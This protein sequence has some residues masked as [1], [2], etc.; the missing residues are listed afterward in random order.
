M[1]CRE[2]ED[3]I[4]MILA[5]GCAEEMDAAC[6]HAAECSRCRG[7]LL[8]V[9][10]EIELPAP[11]EREPLTQAIMN[12]TTGPAC[13]GAQERLCDWV[14]GLCATEDQEILAQHVDHCPGCAGIASTLAELAA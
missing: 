5:A 4:E 7:L 9:R 6:L 14:D 8:A 2:F 11:E 10:G 1:K 3:R 12:R 13:P